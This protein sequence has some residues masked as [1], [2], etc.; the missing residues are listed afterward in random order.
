MKFFT[1]PWQHQVEAIEKGKYTKNLLLSHD[2]GT[3]K[4]F[5]AVHILRWRCAVERRLLRTL[6]I[7]PIVVL[8]NWKA[9]FDSWSKI[10]KKD[11]VVLKGSGMKK[12]SQVVQ[13]T[14]NYN[15]PKIIITNLE[16]L[17]NQELMLN[18]HC[19]RPEMIIL[20]ESHMCKN[21]KSKRAKKVLSL[22]DN[23]KFKLLLTGTPILNSIEDLF[24]QFRI[25]DRGE[26]FGKN[27]FAFRA[28]Y[29]YDA[30]AAWSS[31]PGHFPCYQPRPEMLDALQKLIEKNMHR[32]VKSQCLDLPPYIVLNR[33]VELSKEQRKLYEEMKRDFITFVNDEHDK[34]RAV[35]AQL[36][37]TKALRMLQITTG[38]VKTEEGE[39]IVIKHNPRLALLE[40]LLEQVTPEHKVIVWALFKRNHKEI[41]LVCKKLGVNFV[42][43]NGDMSTKEKEEAIKSF[44]TLPSVKV[45]IANQQAGGTG[46]NLQQASYSIYYSRGFSFGQ[47]VQSEARCYRGGSEIHEKVTRINLI[48]KDTIDCLVHEALGK[49]ED[50]SKRIIDKAI[51]SKL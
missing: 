12:A 41:A 50:L 17:Q 24:M 46:V 38:F 31:R 7:C 20:D 26:T 3:G 15:F 45:M 1:K 10:D 21:Y 47:D 11:V 39:E 44:Q 28:T 27:F 2:V 6:I 43:L 22:A 30:N 5:S 51:I 25:L 33:E 16:S 34:P 8:G 32:A 18:L 37:L 13:V 9:S 36:A 14:Q 29:M 19:F 23:A 49:K 4:T 42:H 48:A 40:D 35:V